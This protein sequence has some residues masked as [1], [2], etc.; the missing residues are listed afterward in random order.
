MT[1]ENAVE[2][3]SRLIDEIRHDA[4]WRAAT[5]A[6]ESD[7]IDRTDAALD[8]ARDPTMPAPPVDS[9]LRAAIATALAA[10]AAAA[11]A[12][13]PPTSS[14][15]GRITAILRRLAG[16]RAYQDQQSATNA[17]VLAALQRV[18]A[19]LDPTDPGSTLGATWTALNALSS[20]IA[21]LDETSAAG[22][23]R[24][25][26]A[27]ARTQGTLAGPDG[28]AERVTALEQEIEPLGQLRVAI[29][30]LTGPPPTAD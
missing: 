13:P 12:A 23:A 21:E 18:E 14:S 10:V 5:T 30:G 3:V 25:Q 22:L 6:A 1:E 24:T 28:L 29:D 17:Q 2:T 20:R 16:L 15:V 27:L 8:G 26:R 4:G 11:A 19:A 9:S 7:A